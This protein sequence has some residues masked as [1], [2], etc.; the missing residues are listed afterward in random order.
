MKVKSF[1]AALAVATASFSTHAVPIAGVTLPFNGFGTATFE[2][3][4]TTAGA[5]T[6]F[7]VFTLIPGPFNLTTGFAAT[8]Q[9]LSDIDFTSITIA[10]TLPPPESFSF[11]LIQADPL[12]E[13]WE[14]PGSTYLQSGVEYQLTVKGNF[15][16]TGA[17]EY[18]GKLFTTA[19]PEPETYAL[20]LAGLGAITFVARRRRAIR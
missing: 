15:A 16:G 11:A 5:F 12:T 3:T 18:T 17:A 19:V 14:V 8:L 20:F 7:W 13:V 6:D 9:G 1:V 10:R 2:N 4:L